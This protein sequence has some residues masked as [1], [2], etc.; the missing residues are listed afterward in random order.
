MVAVAILPAHSYTFCEICRFMYIILRGY[1][2]RSFEFA[3]SDAARER[4]CDFLQDAL[5]KQHSVRA[6][7]N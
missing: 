3:E 2:G 4:I 7:L 6:V 5:V 1:A